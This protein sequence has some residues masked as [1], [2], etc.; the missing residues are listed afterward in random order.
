M[1]VT[2]NSNVI[3]QLTAIRHGG[4]K[5]KHEGRKKKEEEGANERKKERKEKIKART[6]QYS[7]M[8]SFVINRAFRNSEQSSNQQLCV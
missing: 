5:T 7:A 1:T 4:C 3:I 8:Y 6:V 2:M